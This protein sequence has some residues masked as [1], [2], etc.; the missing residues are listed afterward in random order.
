MD[1]LMTPTQSNLNLIIHR[2]IFNALVTVL[3]IS[4]C[5]HAFS[6]HDIPECLLR[7]ALDGVVEDCV[8]FVGVDLNMAGVSMLR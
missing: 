3:V 8:S 5:L 1:F 4:F 7:G 2:E 6:Q